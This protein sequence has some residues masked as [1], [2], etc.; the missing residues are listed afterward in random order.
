[1]SCLDTLPNLPDNMKYVCL[2]FLTNKESKHTVTGVRFGGAYST[3]EEACKQAKAIQQLD[4]YHNVFVGEGGKWLP[5]DPDPNS[6]AVKDS[7]YADARLNE[8]MK[9]HKDSQEKAK[10]FHEL[11]KT[12]K[13]MDNINDNIKEKNINKTELTN[14][15]SN[16]ANEEEMKVITNYIDNIDEQLKKME[17]QLKE[18]KETESK[19][20]K[21]I[22]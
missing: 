16:A 8:L 21:T 5:Y 2:S 6:E 13:M 3:Y 4:Q 20:K 7:E 14:K 19:L 22:E 1:M 12:E 10:I 17:L 9:G 11:R 18:C 15:L